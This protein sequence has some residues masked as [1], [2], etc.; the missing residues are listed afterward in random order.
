MDRDSVMTPKQASGLNGDFY[1]LYFPR[2]ENLKKL[3]AWPG[4]WGWCVEDNGYMKDLSQ[5]AKQ[6]A[7]KN[8]RKILDT[9]H[10]ILVIGY[11]IVVPFY[12]LLL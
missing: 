8:V 5:S 7:D 4:P 10:W 1:F 2:I 3:L 12:F 11:L 9:T 6:M